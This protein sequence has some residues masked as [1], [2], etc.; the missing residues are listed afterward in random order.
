MRDTVREHGAGTAF[1][2]DGDYLRDAN[3][4]SDE[5]SRLAAAYRADAP[6]RRLFIDEITAVT[7]WERGLKRVLDRGE[8]R[9]V[10][11]VTTGSRATDLRHGSEGLPG[12]PPSKPTASAASRSRRSSRAAP[13]LRRG[14]ASA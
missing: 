5:V 8:L 3:H 13:D 10:L 2:L 11:V 1:F 7:D 4:L 14:A 9:R 12:Q 6:V